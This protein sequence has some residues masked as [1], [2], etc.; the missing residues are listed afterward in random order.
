MSVTKK[1]LDIVASA[2]IRDANGNRIDTTYLKVGDSALGERIIKLTDA[3]T[4]TAG[5]WLASA[6]GVSSYVDGQIFC[7]EVA[8]AGA[9]T[10]TLNVN[11]LGAKT[12]YR[13][14]T[15]KLTTQYGVGQYVLLVYN[16]TND[17]FR[18]VNDYDA[19][20]DSKVRQYQ[21][22]SNSAGSGTKYPILTR[23]ALTNKNGSYDAN[24]ARFHTDVTIDTSKG[25]L[26]A[27]AIYE[28]GLLVAT[29][30]D[31]GSKQDKLVSGTN[32]KTI[33]GNSI[34]GSGNIEIGGG[35]G[36]ADYATKEEIDA[37]FE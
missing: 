12:V 16:S 6:N 11:G 14:G 21:S 17:C 24:Y 1:K 31:L 18:V 28:G 20:S 3:G 5:T 35:G 13:Y 34:L 4:T 33:N 29:T 36:G 10:T 25:A 9:S 22:G 8:E 32:I 15:T 26:Y 27:N 30:G 23:Y 37:M 7:Y 2:A 19:N